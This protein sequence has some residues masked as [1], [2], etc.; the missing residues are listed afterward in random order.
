V[1]QS[2]EMLSRAMVWLAEAEASG[3]LVAAV[4]ELEIIWVA[5]GKVRPQAGSRVRMRSLISA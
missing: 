3:R 1:P 2:D 5:P 4:V